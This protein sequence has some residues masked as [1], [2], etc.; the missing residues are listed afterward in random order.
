MAE[1]NLFLRDLRLKQAL[2][3]PEDSFRRF[4]QLPSAPPHRE[5]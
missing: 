4:G 3:M 5:P 1:K 2:G